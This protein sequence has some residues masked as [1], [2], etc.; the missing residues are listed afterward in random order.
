MLVDG[1]SILVKL[2]QNEVQKVLYKLVLVMYTLLMILGGFKSFQTSELF[3]NQ[4]NQMC[5]YLTIVKFLKPK[6][7]L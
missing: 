2:F 6:T 3:K 1:R 5:S 4:Q 7:N